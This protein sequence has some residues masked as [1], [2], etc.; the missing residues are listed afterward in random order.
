MAK[1]P[2]LCR[3]RVKPGLVRGEY[4]NHVI[5]CNGIISYYAY[6]PTEKED[7]FP[8]IS[9]AANLRLLPA[10]ATSLRRE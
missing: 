7:F 6:N 5:P 9:L 8:A 10:H 4:Q 2:A 1:A 3:E